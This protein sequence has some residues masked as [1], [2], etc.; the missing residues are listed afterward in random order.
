MPASAGMTKVIVGRIK[1]RQ[2]RRRQKLSHRPSMTKM[3]RQRRLAS[4]D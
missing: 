1:S 3:S 4:R 2:R